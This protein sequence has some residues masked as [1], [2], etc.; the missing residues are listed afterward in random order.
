[1][2]VTTVM[3]DVSFNGLIEISDKEFRLIADLVYEKSGINLTKSKIPLVRGRLNKLIRNLGFS[4]FGE[5][6]NAVVRDPTGRSLLTMIDRIS[7][8]HSYF[9]RE[10]EHFD[11]LRTFVLPQL[12]RKLKYKGDNRIRI[13]CA[14]CACGEEAYSLAFILD[15]FIKND[16]GNWDPGICATD[17]SLSSL[18]HALT[19]VYPCDKVKKVPVHFMNRYLHRN[20]NNTYKVVSRI[21]DMILFKQHNLMNEKY[22]FKGKFHI[23]FLRNVMIYFDQKT[24]QHIV[25]KIHTY[26][27]DNAYLFIGLSESLG[28]ISGEFDYV[29]PSV[30]R[31]L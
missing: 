9:F 22:P 19:G 29:R 31:R 14:G 21:K 30:Y 27:H 20:E 18:E 10:N 15:D 13:W 24:R 4:S 8:N 16:M 3:D 6:Y 5:Y 12:A 23:V 1:M 26:M 25:K 7:T 2:P 11:Y 17:I 28:R